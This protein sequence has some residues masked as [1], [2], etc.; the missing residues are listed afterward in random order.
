MAE[1]NFMKKRE[2]LSNIRK[3]FNHL[4]KLEYDQCLLEIENN[5]EIGLKSTSYIVPKFKNDF[6]LW[7]PVLACSKIIDKL[8]DNDG[9]VTFYEKPCKIIVIHR[10]TDNVLYNQEEKNKIYNKM[11]IEN[12]K[13]FNILHNRKN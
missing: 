6:S 4:V 8:R 10:N 3:K 5:I 11:E 12:Y 1:I 7:D 2:H 9:Y 13:T